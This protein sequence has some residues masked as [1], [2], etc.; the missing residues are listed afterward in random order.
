MGEFLERFYQRVSKNSFDLYVGNVTIIDIK[1]NELEGRLFTTHVCSIKDAIIKY[2]INKLGDLHA[3]IFKKS[4]LLKSKMFFN[5]HINYAEDGLFYA[6]YLSKIEI[7]SIDDYICYMYERRESG[8]SFKMN[9]F[10]SEKL[11][12]YSYYNVVEVL[13]NKIQQPICSLF[14]VW[15]A[16]RYLY[17]M[18]LDCTLLSFKKEL[19]SLDINKLNLVAHSIKQ[20]RLGYLVSNCICNRRFNLAFI[21]LHFTFFKKGFI[22]IFRK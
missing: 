7:V 16:F 19:L 21:L 3:K 8:L 2:K 13:A 1:G 14:N 15:I 22:K 18:F 9:S 6:E 20:R 5:E 4:I 17:T 12:F 10:F 11:C